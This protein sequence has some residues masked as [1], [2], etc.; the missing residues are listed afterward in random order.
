MRPAPVGP[1]SRHRA[2]QRSAARLDPEVVELRST[3]LLCRIV[4]GLQPS[5]RYVFFVIGLVV[6]AVDAEC[7]RADPRGFVA[8]LSQSTKSRTSAEVAR[9]HS[10]STTRSHHHQRSRS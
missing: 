2:D 8:A 5:S 6:P 9:F 3:A 1:C 10:T 4:R 7:V